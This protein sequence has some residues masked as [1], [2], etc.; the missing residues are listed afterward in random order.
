MP[1]A[2]VC[3]DPASHCLDRVMGAYCNASNYDRGQCQQRV[4][5]QQKKSKCSMCGK[6]TI[7]LYSGAC[8]DCATGTYVR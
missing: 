1:A 5:D 8:Y 7:E 6:K 4:R 2:R 3:G